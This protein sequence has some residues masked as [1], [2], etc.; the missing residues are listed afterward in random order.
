MIFAPL[1]FLKIDSIDISDHEGA[2]HLFDLNRP[3]IEPIISSKY[4]LV[5]DCGTMEHLFDIPKVMKHAFTLL[6]EG[7][8]VIYM[9][10]GNNFYDHGFYQISPLLL[11]EYFEA[12]LYDEIEV[13]VMEYGFNMYAHP[14]TPMV[15]RLDS[16]R[17]W[18]YDY[19]LMR[20]NSFGKLGMGLYF[21]V[22][23]A[24]KTE[25]SRCDQIPIQGGFAPPQT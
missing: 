22:A 19:N 25:R 4:D 10:P 2:T 18:P 20:M 24:R 13:Y 23:C 14:S 12:N 6:K 7:G 15:Q 5:I 17:L 21:T 11:K 1:G 8:Y 16:W 3:E 9:L